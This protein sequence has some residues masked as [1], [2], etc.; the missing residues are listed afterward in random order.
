MP[1]STKIIPPLTESDQKRFWAKVAKREGGGC[2][3]WTG[4]V[5]R[6]G[7]GFFKCAGL[8]IRAHRISRTMHDGAIPDGLLVCHHCDNPSCVRPSHM[9][10]G[11]AKDNGQDASSKGRFSNQLR[12][13]LIWSARLNAA[14][15]VEI[16]RLHHLGTPRA[17][18]ASMF[19]VSLSAIDNILSSR[20]W[21]HVA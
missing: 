15:V 7:Y 21:K 16:R 19:S 8:W 5:D 11:T 6:D 20:T 9:F 12:G 1:M 14:A 17:D 4:K 2:W 3:E 18:I 13:E 10:L